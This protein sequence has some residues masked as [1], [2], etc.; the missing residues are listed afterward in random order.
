MDIAAGRAACLCKPSSPHLFRFNAFSTEAHRPASSSRSPSPAISGGMST[1]PNPSSPPVPPLRPAFP[2][3]RLH[4]RRTRPQNVKNGST[5]YHTVHTARTKIQAGGGGR[6][7]IPG[8]Y[9]EM[10]ESQTR[11][12]AMDDF[13]DL[14]RLTTTMDSLSCLHMRHEVL[15]ETLTER[16]RQQDEKEA[17][18]EREAQGGPLGGFVTK[19][20]GWSNDCKREVGCCQEPGET[21]YISDTALTEAEFVADDASESAVDTNEQSGDE[22][23]D[24]TAEE[25]EGLRRRA[26][27]H[28]RLM[29]SSDTFA[30]DADTCQDFTSQSP[31]R[32]NFGNK[33]VDQES[34]TATDPY[35]DDGGE[36]DGTALQ[37]I[38]RA[39]LSNPLQPRSPD[40]HFC[41]KTQPKSP[42]GPIDGDKKEREQEGAG[43]PDR[44]SMA[45]SKV[46]G[47]GQAALD[48]FLGR[49]SGERPGMRS[50]IVMGAD[51]LK[52]VRQGLRQW[53]DSGEYWDKE[54]GDEEEAVVD[55]NWASYSDCEGDEEVI[56]AVKMFWHK[57]GRGREEPETEIL[58]ED[59]DGDEGEGNGKEAEDD[60]D[61][62]EN[63]E[64]NQGGVSLIILNDGRAESRVGNNSST[65]N[66]ISG[67]VS[68]PQ[69]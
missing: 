45:D 60:E 41:P 48:S 28:P 63:E 33:D 14:H 3:P 46:D 55:G 20:W 64:D 36:T 2:T 56:E 67:P 26:Q 5:I 8:N 4:I 51:D 65:E 15:L 6:T 11:T 21:E 7:C 29:C 69:M 30:L 1:P 39:K 31:Y 18:L 66:G 42:Q 53:R 25:M 9:Y 22:L 57:D 44:W 35:P 34:A 37:W 61:Q 23:W 52:A 13:S 50:S 32:L 43:T 27:G 54:W 17:A 19:S 12:E 59:E 62:E 58:E 38:P 68:A 10:S 40:I 16:I 24:C 47:A 49:Q